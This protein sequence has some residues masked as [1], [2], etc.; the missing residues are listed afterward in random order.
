[1]FC[2]SAGLLYQFRHRVMLHVWTGGVRLVSDYILQLPENGM[3]KRWKELGS[4]YRILQKCP[5]VNMKSYYRI[6]L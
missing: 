6:L 4:G 5:I 2:Y 1:M 3:K